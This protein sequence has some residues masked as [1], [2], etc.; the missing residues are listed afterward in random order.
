MDVSHGSAG[1][2]TTPSIA[3]VV[4]SREWP[5]ISR[6]RVAVRTQSPKTEMIANLF[7]PVSDK[8]DQGIVKE[9]LLDFYKSFELQETRADYYLQGWSR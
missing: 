8:E 2:S 9:L 6:Y 5:L 7:K 3:A 4:S 1:Q